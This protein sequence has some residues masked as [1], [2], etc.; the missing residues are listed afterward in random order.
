MQARTTAASLRS[1]LFLVL[2]LAGCQSE[3]SQ[4]AHLVSEPPYEQPPEYFVLAFGNHPGRWLIVDGC[5]LY[6][7]KNGNGNLQEPG[8][9]FEGR[10]E[11]GQNLSYFT[12]ERR[13][14]DL[15]EVE[16]FKTLEVTIGTYN[17]N[18]EPK[19]PSSE[20]LKREL[21]RIPA[22]FAT[23]RASRDDQDYEFVQ[24]VPSLDPSGVRVL[25]F[26]GAKSLGFLDVT[27]PP[28]LDRRQ[29]VELQLSVGTPGHGPWTLVRHSYYGLPEEARPSATVTFP[30]AR[31]GA[32]SVV[33]EI[34]FEGKC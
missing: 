17:R 9:H 34:R 14:F 4:L 29:A 21:E 33:R 30:P 28:V 5:H 12:R 26:S 19:D 27:G 23:I 31:P 20:E 22:R 18:F 16:G 3:P 13:Q 24:T 8:E 10:Q 11:P 1:A 6:F 7:D 2:V 25:S 32:E 15:G